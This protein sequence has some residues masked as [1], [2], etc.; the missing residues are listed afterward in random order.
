[1]PGIMLHLPFH[2]QAKQ[3]NSTVFI[4]MGFGLGLPG[5]GARDRSLLAVFL[6]SH[7]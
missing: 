6:G 2:I 7:I 5:V 4:H 3:N 1:M